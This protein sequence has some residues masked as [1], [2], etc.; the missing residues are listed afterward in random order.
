[1]NIKKLLCAISAVSLLALC[2]CGGGGDKSDGNAD[3]GLYKAGTY[4]ASAYGMESDVTVTVTVG[5]SG[6][7][8]DVQIDASGE[9]VGLGQDVPDKL[10]PKIKEAQSAEIDGVTGATL[11]S[12][13]AI[14]ALKDCL[15]QAAK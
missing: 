14:N 5:E 9:T 4:T 10:I 3:T 13:A 15:S 2:A 6:K 7:I 8:D 12:D 11:T 1:M